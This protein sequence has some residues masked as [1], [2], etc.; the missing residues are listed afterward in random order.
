MSF[1]KIRPA[2]FALNSKLLSSEMTTFDV[3]HAN[4]VDKTGDTFN[5][6]ITAGNGA[7]VAVGGAA[8]TTTS[9]GSQVLPGAGP[10][11]VFNVASTAG[12]PTSGGINMSP[13]GATV[14]H[15]AYTGVTG[16]TFTGCTTTSTA[17]IGAGTNVST[18][19]YLD[20]TPA[21]VVIAEAGSS[22]VFNNVP[23]FVNGATFST[24]GT[25]AFQVP[26]SLGTGGSIKTANGSAARMIYADNDYPILDAASVHTG[27]VQ[28]RMVPIYSFASAVDYVRANQ[29][30]PAALLDS[31]FGVMTHATGDIIPLTLAPPLVWNGATL[32]KVT[33]F[34]TPKNTHGSLPAAAPYMNVRRHILAVGGNVL[35]GSDELGVT[36][37]PATLPGAVGTWN[38]SLIK[39]WDYTCTVNNVLDPTQ[40]VYRVEI[41]EEL[42][43]GA[44][45]GNQYHAVLL[46]YAIT[47]LRPQ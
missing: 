35:S 20:I 12:F 7:V 25:A 9:T 15:I 42:G 26:L 16:T 21:G 18:A 45:A 38:N 43:G 47:D 44:V 28:T 3:D 40:Y 34:F 19:A 31:V 36:T 13:T 5:A 4:A 17:T 6:V 11:F 10:T 2:G 37:Q 8:I 30:A 32:S 41:T 1:T 27:R 46:T 29:A 24:A 22:I 14:I 33:C 23:S 39:S